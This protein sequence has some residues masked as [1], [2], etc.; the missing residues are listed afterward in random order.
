MNMGQYEL[1]SYFKS[2]CDSFYIAYQQVR[3]LEREIEELEKTS[4]EQELEL[5]EKMKPFYEVEDKEFQKYI[6]LRCSKE[7]LESEKERLEEFQKKYRQK[8]A[9]LNEICNAWVDLMIE[10]RRRIESIVEEIKG[11]KYSIIITSKA[12]IYALMDFYKY[13]PVKRFPII[14]EEELA[15]K[16]FFA[17]GTTLYEDFLT[18]YHLDMQATSFNCSSDTGNMEKVYE[19]YF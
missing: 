7:E 5:L 4:K 1:Q 3:R 17:E 9:K 18:A 16:T 12:Q 6:S 10:D 19:R 11:N 2:I 8:L 14:N 13:Y 15:K